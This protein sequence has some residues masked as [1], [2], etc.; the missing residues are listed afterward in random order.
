MPQQNLLFGS[1]NA[2]KTLR[3]R[4]WEYNDLGQRK[5]SRQRDSWREWCMYCKLNYDRNQGCGALLE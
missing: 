5:S 1:S 2:H 3:W 4:C